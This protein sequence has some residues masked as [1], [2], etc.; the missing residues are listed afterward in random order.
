MKKLL[1][2]L[3]CALLIM[4]GCGKTVSNGLM[5]N[6]SSGTSALSF[7]TYDGKT[8]TDS[9]IFDTPTT[10]RLLNELD[11]VKA[12]AA[13]NWS[14]EDITLPI[15][16]LNIGDINGWGIFV[17]WSNGYWIT[18]TGKAYKFNYDFAA[19]AE[20]YP[21]SDKREFSDF[22][23]M[24]CAY[25]LA[26]DENGWS[27]ALLTP[28]AEQKAPDG[29]AMS[30]E[31][32]NKDAV[33]VNIKN[34]SGEDW[35]YGEYFGLEVQLDGVWYGIPTTPENWGFP[36]IGLIVPSGKTREHTYTLSMYGELPAGTYRL[37]THGLSVEHA[38]A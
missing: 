13:D 18:Q 4:S 8:V 30:L 38:A 20:K 9:T 16:G 10:Q 22:S 27:S 7:Y 11:A 2:I 17:A 34:N 32:W 1:P 14:L 15:Y 29:I 28:A 23:V 19:L 24:P 6:A 3:L 36:S 26:Q 33:T 5:K 21:V 35:M 31:A 25:H 37:V 12:T